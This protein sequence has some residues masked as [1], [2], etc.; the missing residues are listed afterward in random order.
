MR[1][2]MQKQF[3]EILCL[4]LCICLLSGCSSP[5]PQ[6]SATVESTAAAAD[7]RAQIRLL[8]S[9]QSQW[10]QEEAQGSV[11]HYAVTDLDRNGRLEILAMSTQGTGVY[12]YGN[13]FEVSEDG[14]SL[15]ECSLPF[16]AGDLP[17]MIM[18][19]VPAAFDSA[20]GTYYY[21]FRDSHKNGAAEYYES[22]QAISMKDGAVSTKTLSRMS[23]VA[24]DGV[25]KEEYYC[26]DQSITQA[27]YEAI[28]PE[29]QSGL[30]GFTADLE[31]LTL[32]AGMDE[33][34]LTK[35]LEA[36]EASRN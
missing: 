21:L 14:S 10:Q 12:T 2:K 30:E 22:I 17:E 26:G 16:E 27:E 6:R 15:L 32:E 4:A 31:W 36:F 28:I 20:D 13:I 5:A 8:A 18:D 7:Y 29:F 33:A 34:A 25:A 23:L 9:S 35:S 11:Y 19:V 1:F 24:V 3:A